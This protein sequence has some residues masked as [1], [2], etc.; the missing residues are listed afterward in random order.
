[1]T[2]LK[3]GVLAL[4]GALLAVGAVAAALPNQASEN[5]RAH[6]QSART[7]ETNGHAAEAANASQPKDN[8]TRGQGLLEA[9]QHVPEHVRAHLQSVWDAL[10]QGVRGI[11][12]MLVKPG[13]PA[14]IDTVG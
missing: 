3:L 12:D 11:G 6:A 5:A 9:L 10:S 1:M 14:P 13:K 8:A 2:N 7:E 4:A